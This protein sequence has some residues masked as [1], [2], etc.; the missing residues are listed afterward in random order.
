MSR[1]LPR[2]GSAL[3]SRLQGGPRSSL[4]RGWPC[5]LPRGLKEGQPQ[6]RAVGR[7]WEQLP[8]AAH[9]GPQG[10]LGG[11]RP[12]PEPGIVCRP[13]EHT[14][15]EGLRLLPGGPLLGADSLGLPSPDLSWLIL[16][17]ATMVGGPQGLLRE[18]SDSP[19]ACCS[20]PPPTPDPG[21]LAR[22]RPAAPHP[23]SGGLR[24]AVRGRSPQTSWPAGR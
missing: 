4:P 24:R 7:W 17:A 13:P 10:R 20:G 19:D 11:E 12:R 14:T 15:S 16:L 8:F 9:L 2:S 22:P 21:P 5:H 3:S 1:L 18:S 23:G 6:D